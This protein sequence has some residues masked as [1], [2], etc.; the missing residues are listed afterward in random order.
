MAETVSR[1]G[2]LERWVKR[3]SGVL[4]LVPAIVLAVTFFSAFHHA[5]ADKAFWETDEFYFFC[6]GGVVWMLCF[7]GSIWACGEPRPLRLYV[8]GHELTHA[9]WVWAL[10]GSVRQ[11]E[12]RRQ[13][14]FIVTTKNNFWIALAPYFYPLYS[15]AVIV[16]YA[17]ASLFYDVAQA[18]AVSIFGTPLQWFFLA[19]GLTWAFHISFTCWMLPKGQ[20]DITAHGTFFSLVLIYLMNLLTIALFLIVAAPEVTFLSFGR[21]LWGNAEHFAR[22]VLRAV[23]ALHG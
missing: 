4:L 1:P 17:L 15:M 20:S 13:G 6:L 22:L 8:F 18:G 21:E 5:T 10:G 9:V 7:F 2:G 11:F 14:G 19:L 23:G 16:I 3:L 12:V